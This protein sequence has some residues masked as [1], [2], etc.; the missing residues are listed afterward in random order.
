[1]PHEVQACDQHR[2]TFV[3]AWS[4]RLSQLASA[5]VIEA[6]TAAACI[7]SALDANSRWSFP[8]AA[9]LALTLSSLRACGPRPF[10]RRTMGQGKK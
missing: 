7:S 6:T 4:D 9:A 1:M 10:P 2:V 3:A 5:S 8:S